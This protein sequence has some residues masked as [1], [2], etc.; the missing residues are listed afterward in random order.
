[1][2]IHRTATRE[3]GASALVPEMLT[4]HGLMMRL[5]AAAD[6]FLGQA[7]GDA[8]G[9][10]PNLALHAVR[11]AGMVARL[12][13]RYRSGVIL[14]DRLSRA[15]PAG[16]FAIAARAAWADHRARAAIEDRNDR[17]VAA[18]PAA[19]AP[20]GG[21]LGRLRHGN[22]PGDFRTAPRCGARTRA[23]GC[24]RQPAMANG[25]CRLHGGMST[26]PR[27]AAGLQRSRAARLV[28]GGRARSLLALRAAAAQ[29]AARLA[30]LTR[31][32]R[33]LLAGHGV[34]GSDS[35]A[36]PAS[37]GGGAGLDPRRAPTLDRG[38]VAI[39]LRRANVGL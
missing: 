9:A 10:V 35:I 28:Q 20:S 33:P 39:D 26:G 38:A 27:T 19:P 15:D 22:P 11:T 24:C 8:T 36:A 2:T 30:R 18:A 7:A 3:S 14:L 34:H 29:S 31:L 17:V 37:A 32:K 1:M 21:G 25:R 6:G 13:D 5:A 4:G 16:A 23:G 12:M